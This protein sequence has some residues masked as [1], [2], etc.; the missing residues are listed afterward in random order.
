MKHLPTLPQA[1]TLGLLSLAL[2]TPLGAS[3]K[4][5]NTP[6]PLQCERDGRLQACERATLYEWAQQRAKKQPR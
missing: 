4:T 1:L 6:N 3:A 5:K 2:A